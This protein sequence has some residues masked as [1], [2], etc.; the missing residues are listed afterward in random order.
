MEVGIIGIGYVGLPTAIGL[1]CYGHNIT[2][3]DTNK[4]KIKSLN[5][6]ELPIYEENMSLY[7]K[8]ARPRLNFSNNFNDLTKCEFII[9]CVGT[10]ESKSGE[11]DLS[12]IMQVANLLNVQDNQIIAI[13]S[14]VPIGTNEQFAEVVRHNNKGKMFT[15]ISMPEFLREGFAF[16]DFFNPDRIIIGCNNITDKI[17]NTVFTLYPSKLKNKIMFTDLKSAEL[18]KYASNAFLAT[19][20]HYIN[21]L[22]N[23]CE[24][25]GA[26]IKSVADG[27]GLDSRIGNKFL[28]AGAGYGGSCFPKDTE[29]LKFLANRAGINLEIVN[30]VIEGNKKR[31]IELAERILKKV[32][33]K[34]SPI[35]TFCGISFKA[36]T[37]DCRE[38]SA[39]SIIKYIQSHNNNAKIRCYDLLAQ[40]NA[41]QLIPNTDFYDNIEFAISGADLIVIMNEDEQFTKIQTDTPIFDYRGIMPITNN[42]YKIG[43]NNFDA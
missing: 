18:I 32:N 24:K 11:A 21:E 23:L 12:Y 30:T 31:K 13:K 33:N 19:K 26:N 43:I 29:A 28:V 3:V 4:D 5:D 41:M 37:D 40:K 36:N 34:K 16:D 7:F 15:Q 27:M 35:I 1:A 14:T 20:I 6:G 38:S 39:I 42:T 22:A 10:P 2:C 17:K 8:K 9:I 25:I